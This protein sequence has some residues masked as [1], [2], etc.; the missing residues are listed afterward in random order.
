MLSSGNCSWDPTICIFIF[1]TLIY[2]ASSTIFCSLSFPWIKT[3]PKVRAGKYEQQSTVCRVGTFFF[4]YQRF[5]YYRGW[6]KRNDHCKQPIVDG[7]LMDWRNFCGGV[8]CIL[9][10]TDGENLCSV[11]YH[12]ERKIREIITVECKM[13]FMCLINE[14]KH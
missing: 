5:C 10:S 4:F 6:C 8:H 1:P 7:P 3:F 11:A 9:L 2:Y 13:L 12:Y 14:K